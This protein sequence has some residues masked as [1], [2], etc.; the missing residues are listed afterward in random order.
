MQAATHKQRA[1]CAPLTRQQDDGVACLRLCML[2]CSQAVEQRR[3]GVQE[4]LF[5][6]LQLE[7]RGL[8]ATLH[9]LEQQGAI[10][11]LAELVRSLH[12]SP[13]AAGGQIT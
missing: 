10:G 2:R 8:V 11:R 4:R 3:Q 5:R 12:A 6:G 9:P 7:G 1:L 13:T